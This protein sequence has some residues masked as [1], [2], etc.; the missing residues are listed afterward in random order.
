MSA[1]VQELNLASLEA[2]IAQRTKAPTIREAHGAKY[3]LAPLMDEAA[4]ALAAP[5]EGIET[6]AQG[7]WYTAIASEAD[8]VELRRRVR[9]R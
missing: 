8:R 3:T 9:M 2:D 1:R 5:G 4:D 7:F 6:D